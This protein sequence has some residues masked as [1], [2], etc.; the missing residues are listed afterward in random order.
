MKKLLIAIFIL[1]LS[2]PAFAEEAALGLIYSGELTYSGLPVNA[3]VFAL[4]GGDELIF[5]WKDGKFEVEYP[6]GKMN[7]AGEVFLKW[8]EKHFNKERLCK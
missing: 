5:N 1:S 8:L 4:G 7:E 6:P 2:F 3:V